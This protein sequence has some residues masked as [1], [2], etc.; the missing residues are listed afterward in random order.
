MAALSLLSCAPPDN[1]K[2][3]LRY[4]AWGN[5]EQMALEEKLC[6]QFGQENPDIEVKFFRVPGSAYLNK[7]IVMFASRTAPDVVRIDHYNFPDLVRKNYFLNL[8]PLAEKD[9]GFRESDFFPTTISE[10]KYKGG[11]YGLNVMFGGEIMYYN[12]K[13]IKE[14]GLEDPYVLAKKGEWTYDRFLKHA[15]AMT[16][17]ENGRVT[18]FGC[19]VPSFPMNVPTIWAFGGDILTPDKKRSLLDLP[20]SIAA[21]QFLADLRW[22]HQCAPTPAQAAQSAYS[23]ESGKLGMEF[24]WMGSAPRY[25]SAI[26]TFDW[27]ICPIPVGPAGNVSMIKGNQIVIYR[28]TKHPEAAWR[29]IRFLTSP[30]V[31]KLLYVD[32]R[33]NF[34]TRKSVAYSEAFLKPKVRPFQTDVFLQAVEKARELPINH[35]WS[36]WNQVLSSEQDNLYSGRERDAEIVMKRAATRINQVLADEEGF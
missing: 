2:I 12:K 30:E 33:R 19:A 4:M 14:A 22:K 28:E 23:F 27:D 35:R 3:K 17:R 18:S 31:E 10:G 11:L 9:K 15:I 25:N 7:A 32:N 20:G 1:G 36:E 8:S 21:Y 29:F 26:K 6:E 13:L 34:P 16:K 5:P 24:G